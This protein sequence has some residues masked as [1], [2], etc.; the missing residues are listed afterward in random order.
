MSM[1]TGSQYAK[2]SF[3]TNWPVIQVEVGYY[4]LGFV[5]QVASGSE[6]KMLASRTACPCCV[7]EHR[8]AHSACP[9]T[10]LTASSAEMGFLQYLCRQ[11]ETVIFSIFTLSII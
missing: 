10:S 8:S 6:E 4:R 3:G 1:K 2:V 11:L 5:D 7:E 9:G